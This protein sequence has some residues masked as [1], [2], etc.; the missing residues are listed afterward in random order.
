V[1]RLTRERG[2]LMVRRACASVAGTI[3]PGTLARALDDDALQAGLGAR[4]LMAMPPRHRRVWSERE[5]PDDIAERYQ[6][7]LAELLALPM[8]NA[9]KREPYVLGLSHVAKS[10]WVRF[11]NEW[12]KVQ[13]GAEGEQASAMAKLEAAAARL[14][15]IHH[16]VSHVAAGTDD[17][18]SII[19]PSMQAGI[20]LA[21]WFANEAT[22]VYAML[23][24]DETS[25]R[26]RKLLEWIAA[27]GE[28]ILGQPEKRGV[29]AKD[30]QRSNSRRW[31]TS[32]AAG[33]DLESLVNA[34]LGEWA[35]D[36]PR[37]SGGRRKKWFVVSEIAPD[38]SDDCYDDPESGRQAPSDDC[39]DDCRQGVVGVASNPNAS[40]DTNGTYDRPPEGAG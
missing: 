25:R 7:L 11:F 27:H 38:V 26:T 20:T 5:L 17:T 24:E 23:H 10:E 15:L 4:F 6:R 2:P 1:D 13:H 29:T 30:L 35:E 21:H 37:P 22:R 9:T 40:I 16:V 34:G 19:Q 28:P 3:Q 8:R 32:E 33:S 18:K 12:G 31:P 39:S 14:A 36:A